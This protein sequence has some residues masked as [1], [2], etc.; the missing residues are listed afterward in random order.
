M[1]IKRLSQNPPYAKNISE[2]VN[3]NASDDFINMSLAGAI[4]CSKKFPQLIGI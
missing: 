4:H 3:V 1:I 2:A